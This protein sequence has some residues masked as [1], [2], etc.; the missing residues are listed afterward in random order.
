MSYYSVLHYGAVLQLFLSAARAAP[1]VYTTMV[2]CGACV[3]TIAQGA[4]VVLKMAK[5]INM[6]SRNSDI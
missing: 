1:C 6:D 2:Q 5:I 3:T 4:L